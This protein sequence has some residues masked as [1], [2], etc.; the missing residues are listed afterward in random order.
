MSVYHVAIEDQT[1]YHTSDKLEG[2]AFFLHSILGT[3]SFVAVIVFTVLLV[4]QL[5][6]KSKW[7]MTANED[8]SASESASTRERKTMT[9]V[10]MIATVLIVCYTP[11]VAL[12][13]VTF[14]EPEFNIVGS[15]KN[16]FLVLWSIAFVLEAVNSSINIILYYKMSTKYKETFHQI[17]RLLNI[18][19]D[20]FVRI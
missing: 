9:M 14:F 15:F 4:V 19:D 8:K 16:I 17:F 6:R 11:G 5:K 13:M 12:S 2:L 3:S 10:A 7:R 18:L 20:R 1:N